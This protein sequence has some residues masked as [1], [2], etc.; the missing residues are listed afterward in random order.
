MKLA[1]LS[2][3]KIK[4]QSFLVM[5]IFISGFTSEAQSTITLRDALKISLANYG[6]IK[7]KANYAAASRE[8]IKQAQ[9]D[10]LPN[11]NLSAQV[12]YGS[13]NGQNGPAYAFGPAGIATSASPL[14]FQNWNAAFG[15][16]YLTNINWDFFAF[17]RAKDRIRTA[18]A[19]AERDDRDVGQEIFQHQVRV[20]AAYLNLLAA[21]RLTESYRKN[22][23]RADTLRN[24]IV[25]KARQDMVAGVD[26]SQANSE[27]SNARSVLLRAMNFEDEQNSVLV[28]L[29]GI[30]PQRIQADT[31]FVSSLPRVIPGGADSLSPQHPILRYYQSRIRL[32]E[33][34]ARY[35]QTFSY[36]TVSLGGVFQ[37]RGSGFGVASGSGYN[38]YNTDFFHGVK[39]DRTNYL[40][41]LGITWN[42]TQPP[43]VK[44]QVKAQRLISDGL[45]DELAL[46]QQQL[47]V[48]LDLSASKIKNAIADYYET[49]LQVK[50][51]NDAY[52][53]KTILYKGGLTNL[54]DVTQAL[55]ALVRA[56][57]DR[58][59][60]YSNVWQALL[61]KA[62][63]Q[64]EFAVF[65]QNL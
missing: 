46:T 4:S 53:Q 10:Y 25:L 60:A 52:M 34:Q 35:Y 40:V 3:R 59:I 50:A 45:K 11:F 6:S 23:A 33:E 22:L 2:G 55:Y 42:I 13:A 27:V 15:A 29:L 47:G 26:S 41:A 58:D 64:G 48:Q 1:I 62:A 43:R 5:M 12:D 19:T 65:A 49:P 61:L 21:Q 7:A 30:S 36:P 37:T 17:G 56:E 63:S 24:I 54:V 57:T 32:S 28:K 31:L 44:Q 9:L 39:P 20:A 14:P 51:A 8:G 18:T 16:L 38:D